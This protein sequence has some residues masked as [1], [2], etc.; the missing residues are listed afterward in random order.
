MLN[1]ERSWIWCSKAKP[2][3]QK[4]QKGVEPPAV[5]PNVIKL[6]ECSGPFRWPLLEG[7]AR[8]LFSFAWHPS[9]G[10]H[11]AAQPLAAAVADIQFP[12]KGKPWLG[13]LAAIDGPAPLLFP[14][15]HRNGGAP[16]EVL[17][18]SAAS[19]ALQLPAWTPARL[20]VATTVA[21]I[22]F[23]RKA[24]LRSGPLAAGPA[25]LLFPTHQESGGTPREV[26]SSFAALDALQLPA[27]MPARTVRNFGFPFLDTSRATVS[28][29]QQ[30]Y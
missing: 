22:Q 24:K 5:L 8:G 2:T 1:L 14:A 12:W 3:S 23:P 28:C 30:H 29:K 13:P 11:R 26:L 6:A 15:H 27:W 17:C 7:P 25:P 16:G 4:S 9:S 18:S 20:S 19:D 10:M 21:V